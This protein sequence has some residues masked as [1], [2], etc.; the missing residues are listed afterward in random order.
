MN[1]SYPLLYCILSYT[2]PLTAI[3]I[4]IALS[5]WFSFWD[6]ALSDLGHAV[7]SSVAPIFNFGLVFGGFLTGL[8]AV[9]YMLSVDWLKAYILLY[10]GFTLTLIGV[11]DEVYGTIH[12][13]VSVLFFLGMIVYLLIFSFRSKTLVPIPVAI[14]HII[15]W[16]LHFG[17]DIPPGAAIPELIAVFSYIPF[18]TLDYLRV[19]RTI[20][21]S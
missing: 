4:A 19:S 16:I 21:K 17:Y 12:F 1:K 18:Y 13:I 11:Y 5:P 7:K 3:F 9:K 15:I 10:M 2:V 14:L 8:I 6:N 20:Y